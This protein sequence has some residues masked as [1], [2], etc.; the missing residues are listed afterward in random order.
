MR[1]DTEQDRLA[2]LPERQTDLGARRQW[3]G[4]TLAGVVRG[5]SHKPSTRHRAL[6]PERAVAS[7][8]GAAT[9]GY[10]LVAAFLGMSLFFATVA[11]STCSHAAGGL[12]PKMPPA[13]DVAVVDMSAD[14]AQSRMTG[15]ALEGLINQSGAEAYV[16]DRSVDQEQLALAQRHTSTLTGVGGSLGSL[17]ALFKRYQSRVKKMYIYDPNKDW[18]F[19]L[20][21]MSSSQSSGIPVTEETARALADKFGWKGDVE[22]SRI[23][24]TRIE[25]YEWALSHLMP[26]CSR[27]V[28]FT[29]PDNGNIPL[30]DYV[31]ASKGFV[32]RLDLKKPGE[33]AEVEK[34]FAAGAYKVGSSLM[35]YNGDQMNEIANK[36]NIGLVASDYYA[37]GS[38]WSSFPD[39]TYR[40]RTGSAVEAVPGKIYVSLH[41]SDGDNIQFDQNATYRLWRDPLRGVVP[42]ATTLSPTLQEVNSPLL[43]WYY[44]NVTDND[45]LIAGPSGFQFI[46]GRDFNLKTFPKWSELNRRWVADAGFH[47]ANIWV[48]PFPSKQ[49]SIYLRDNA[50][51]GVFHNANHI[52]G[53]QTEA[54]VP[55]VDEGGSPPSNDIER[56]V[57]AALSNKAADPT[58][59]VFLSW[60]LIVASFTR[61]GQSGYAKVNRI[62]DRL[63]S[64]HPGRYV[65]L[66]PR[67]FFATLR[68]YYRMPQSP[69]N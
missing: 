43:D 39:K 14:S 24:A 5:E 38:F 46:Y 1:S 28:V 29:I 15:W 57:F 32:F 40:Q 53:V 30:Y 60:T 61:D 16:I 13:K 56:D 31:I 22:D 11:G 47:T 37:N 64:A 10:S 34:I 21:L 54:G 20:A 52:S 62:V 12:F 44:A 17:G 6:R 63:N 59:P 45:E 35:G 9:P 2:F 8:A 23:G 51:A 65:F 26:G 66:L 4:D 50:L 55:I 48:T 3:D 27:S 42:V 41:W 68:K 33:A 25:G 19:F 36:Y 49:Y 7:R 69:P 58:Q 18:T 67:D